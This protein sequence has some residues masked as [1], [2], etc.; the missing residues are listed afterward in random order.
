MSQLNIAQQRLVHQQIARPSFEQPSQVVHWMGAMQAQDYQHALWAVAVR[1][2]SATLTDVERAIEDRSIVLT[3]PMRGTLH[4]VAAS[5]VRWMLELCAMR[6]ASSASARW[7]QLELDD[8]VMARS[9]AV[10]R[11]ALRGGHALTRSAMLEQL[12]LAGVN[13]AGQR[14]Y[15]I[16]GHLARTGLLCFGPKHG[17]EQTF[18]LL[19]DWLPS[20]PKI[21]REA[22]LAKLAQRY[23]ASHGPAT[24]QDFVHWTGLTL[25]D[26][27]AGLES[28][29]STL[30]SETVATLTYWWLDQGGVS[31]KISK[32]QMHL[33]PGFDEYILGYRDRS[34]VLA[35]EH[36]Q[37]IVPGGN[38]IF[39][40][41]IVVDGQVLGTWK[42]AMK[43]GGIDITLEP[44]DERAAEPARMKPV[45]ERYCQFLGVPLLK[46]SAEMPKT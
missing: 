12:A 31:R 20:V 39:H 38:G 14:G 32:G 26:A 7:R 9:E 11:K 17:K 3:W 25:S 35:A 28:I 34:A 18:V 6:K 15:H 4:F 40:P 5:D 23:F 43:R 46:L 8:S 22:A 42:R 27:R 16:L 1:T 19:D 13:P 30:T 2:Q 21:S 45:L 36:A 41:M 24:I 10:F 33:L 29:Q 44:F 37:R